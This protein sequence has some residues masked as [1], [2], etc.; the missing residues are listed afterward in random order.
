MLGNLGSAG[1]MTPHGEKMLR[2]F[3]N[4]TGF[5][6]DVK[7][8]VPDLEHVTSAERGVGGQ[9]AHF[10]ITRLPLFRMTVGI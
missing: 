3:V 10:T 8:Y 1:Q 2:E 6:S 9:D 7:Q 5:C 4:V